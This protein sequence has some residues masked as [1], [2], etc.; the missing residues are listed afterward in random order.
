MNN[1]VVVLLFQGTY[2]IQRAGSSCYDNG[3]C[4]LFCNLTRG[5]RI[6]GCAFDFLQINNNKTLPRV[7]VT[8]G[9]N[10]E[11]ALEPGDYT[12]FVF[13]WNSGRDIFHI[14]AITMQ[15]SVANRGSS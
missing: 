12:L 13:G 10:Q 4:L 6:E 14:P 9:Q 5:S 15:I 11:Y 2:H 7:Y 8:A 1:F 3:S